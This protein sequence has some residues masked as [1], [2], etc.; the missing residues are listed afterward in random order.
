MNISLKNRTAGFYFAFALIIFNIITAIVYVASY[1][2]SLYMSWLLFAVLLIVA[3][4]G[5]ALYFT[6]YMRYFATASF[7]GSLICAGAFVISTFN[8]MVDAYVGID[9]TSLSAGFI[10]C[11]ILLIIQLVGSFVCNLMKTE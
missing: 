6:G 11:I 1:S 10:C 9:V 8:Y 2:S 3:A 4:A 5:V 7:I